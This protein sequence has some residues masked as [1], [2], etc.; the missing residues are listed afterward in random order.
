M[1]RLFILPLA[2]ALLFGCA[3][4]PVFEPLPRRRSPA[5]KP[6]LADGGQQGPGDPKEVMSFYLHSRYL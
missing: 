5:M 1:K 4:E 6:S 2:V 3:K